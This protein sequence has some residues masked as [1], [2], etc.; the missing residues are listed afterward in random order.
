MIS[1]AKSNW[2]NKDYEYFAFNEDNQTTWKSEASGFKLI[3]FSKYN[4][5]SYT[6]SKVF[7]IWFE[8][9]EYLE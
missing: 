4:S 8:G 9:K 2:S 5:Y 3:N 7:P 1:Y 6:L